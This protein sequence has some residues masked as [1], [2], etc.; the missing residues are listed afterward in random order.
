[1]VCNKDAYGLPVRQVGLWNESRSCW[2]FLALRAFCQAAPVC[3]LPRSRSSDTLKQ[4][5]HAP[6]GFLKTRRKQAVYRAHIWSPVAAH[7][8]PMLPLTAVPT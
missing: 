7:G 4:K 8:A 2:M 5:E 6:V 3:L 1:M